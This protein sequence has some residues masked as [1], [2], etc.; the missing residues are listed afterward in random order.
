MICSGCGSVKPPGRPIPASA[1]CG[2]SR[3]GARCGDQLTRRQVRS[4]PSSRRPCPPFV[5]GRPRC[6]FQIK[7]PLTRDQ[8]AGGRLSEPVTTTSEALRLLRAGDLLYLTLLP[9]GR[10]IWS[11]ARAQ[12]P[13]HH[14]VINELQSGRRRGR[15]IR[16]HLVGQGDALFCDDGLPAQT[17]RWLPTPA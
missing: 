14:E 1:S 2:G 17:W 5:R 3:P 16:G 4:A 12:R 10:R 11:F 6:S 13:C 15:R 7:M 8:A 9:E